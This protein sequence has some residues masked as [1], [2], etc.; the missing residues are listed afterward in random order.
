MKA[1]PDFKMAYLCKK[2]CQLVFKLFLVIVTAGG[3]MVSKG[4]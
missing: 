3:P 1:K 2:K 4:I